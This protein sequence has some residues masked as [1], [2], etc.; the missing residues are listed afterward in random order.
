MKIEARQRLFETLGDTGCFLLAMVEVAQDVLGKYIDA[1]LVYAEALRLGYINELCL[2]IKHEVLLERLTGD[3]WQY[4]KE[5]PDYVPR[6]DERVIEEWKRQ[7]VGVDY[8]HFAYRRP[9]GELVDTLGNSVTIAKG[10]LK[11][12]RVFR[13]IAGR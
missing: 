9:S 10:Y 1:L 13:L 2:V 11:S 12:K 3:D 8:T 4:H 5:A 7:A 6:H